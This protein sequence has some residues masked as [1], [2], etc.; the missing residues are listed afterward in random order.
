MCTAQYLIPSTIKTTAYSVYV[1]LGN[2]SN[3]IIADI[4]IS[5]YAKEC[6]LIP[7]EVVEIND[8]SIPPNWNKLDVI[9]FYPSRL[10]VR[11]K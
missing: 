5:L 1:Y 6:R 7:P 2:C 4:G 3:L 11:N 8:N 10:M 9:I